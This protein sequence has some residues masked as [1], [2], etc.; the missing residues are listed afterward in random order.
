VI[1]VQTRDQEIAAAKKAAK[2]A[3]RRYRHSGT[4]ADWHRM[5]AALEA[6]FLLEQGR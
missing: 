4:G 5:N 6:L 2:N 1:A 3:E